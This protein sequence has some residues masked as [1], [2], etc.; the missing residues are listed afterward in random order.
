MRTFSQ[1]FSYF[2]P[3]NVNRKQ[4]VFYLCLLLLKTNL[5]HT[6]HVV[7]VAQSPRGKLSRPHG[8][9]RD[10]ELLKNVSELLQTV[11]REAGEEGEQC[12]GLALRSKHKGETSCRPHGQGQWLLSTDGARGF[13]DHCRT[14]SPRW[15]VPASR[16]PLSSRWPSQSHP[17][18]WDRAAWVCVIS[19]PTS[20]TTTRNL[21]PKSLRKDHCGQPTGW[22]QSWL[23]STRAPEI[24]GRAFLPGWDISSQSPLCWEMWNLTK[25]MKQKI[26]KKNPCDPGARHFHEATLY[27]S[28]I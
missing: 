6:I 15:D 11:P 14:P 9:M 24:P 8:E 18:A 7:T 5:F 13:N 27:W 10:D 21:L 28:K 26:P 4:T 3:R 20:R 16:L 1:Y 17:R 12:H 22:I 23:S 19:P 25:H 2:S